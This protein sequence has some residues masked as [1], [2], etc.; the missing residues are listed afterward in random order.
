M[1][2]FPSENLLARESSPYLLQHKDN[3]VHWRPWGP[4]IFREARE[5]NRP[6]LLSIGYAACHWCH[7]MAHE[8]FEDEDIAAVMNR[9]FVNVKVDREE[10]PDVDQIYM[11]ALHAL[12]EQGGWPLTMFLTPD[13]E[14]FW[15]GTYFPNT[16]R[17]GRPGFSHILKEISRLFHEEPDKIT[18]NRQALL[19]RLNHRP[20]G[21]G[22]LSPEILGLAAD[23]LIDI[24]DPIEGGPQGAPKFPNASLLELFWRAWKRTGEDRFRDIVLLT[25]RHIAQGGIYDH[26]GGGFSRYSVDEVWLVPHFEKM[27]YDNAQLVALMSDAW[28]V[29][30]DPVFRERIEETIAWLS[31]EM[32]DAGGA[33]TASLDA[34]SD[35]EEGKFYVWTKDEIEA[36]LGAE[37]SALFAAHYDVTDDGN[38]EHK[39]V[40]T[41]RLRPERADEETEARLA[42]CRETLLEARASRIRPGRDDKILADW[43]ALMIGALAKASTVFSRPDWLEMAES[44]YRFISESMLRD[45]RLGHSWCAGQLIWPGLSSDHAG[46]ASAA[47]ALHDATGEASYL[48]DARKWI[49]IL[50]DHY[51]DPDGDYFLTADDAEDLILRPRSAKDEATP[52]PNGVA[53]SALVTL[54]LLTGEDRYR[55]TVDRMF[56]AFTTDIAQNVYMTA[57]LLNAFD[58]RLAPVTAVIVA[59]EGTDPAPLRAVLAA[60][61]DPNIVTSVLAATDTLPTDHPAAGKTAL[62]GRPT[63]YIC[64]GTTCSAPVTDAEALKVLINQP[65]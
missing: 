46:M 59:P 54:W 60:S 51:T 57:A 7:V 18:A 9:L 32:R 16:P 8:S 58:F 28:S 36:V 14:P 10:R 64:Q 48:A 61:A 53:A 13:G 19:A 23:R 11:A 37:D 3:P 4:E 38:W 47:L 63:A 43:N 6:I 21:A 20:A 25:L 40:L 27:L 22:E 26:V 2:E 34:D 15:G 55:A 24:M 31:R 33:F 44:A 56:T 30:G 29:T 35:G 50:D 39:C 5:T 62:G 65:R 41:R 52:N 1:P 42:R 12:G 17:Y 49:A 45:G